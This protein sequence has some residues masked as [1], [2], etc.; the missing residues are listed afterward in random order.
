M[1]REEINLEVE[2]IEGVL[3]VSDD[4]DEICD[5]LLKI[6]NYNNMLSNK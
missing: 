2:Y 1:S 6:Q 4:I 3:E 5:G